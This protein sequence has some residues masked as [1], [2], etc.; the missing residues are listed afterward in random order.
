MGLYDLAAAL[1]DWA[2]AT[3]GESAPRRRNIQVGTAALDDEQIVVE[4]GTLDT[5][6]RPDAQSPN[7]GLGLPFINML[8]T[9]ARAS[10]QMSD[11]GTAPSDEEI[12][13][14]TA[15]LLSDVWLLYNSVDRPD[16]GGLD[17]ILGPF[18][19][20]PRT[21]GII[22]PYGDGGMLNGWQIPFIV[23]IDG[24]FPS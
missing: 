11:D 6:R 13:A 24:F 17:A 14:Y 9:V 23:Q 5:A 2:A 20:K 7:P 10:P 12:N 8:V 1:L 22:V 18:Q 21:V 19:V 4:I 16:D 15:L 3:L